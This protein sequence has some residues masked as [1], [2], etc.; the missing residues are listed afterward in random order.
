MCAKLKLVMRVLYCLPKKRP[1]KQKKKKQNKN[2]TKFNAQLIFN[3]SRLLIYI[4]S[5]VISIT[6]LDTI[7]QSL[8]YFFSLILNTI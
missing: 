3:G 1:K 7:A 4:H 5:A 6:L 2:Q 8:F